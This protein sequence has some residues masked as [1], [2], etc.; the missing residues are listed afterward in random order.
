MPLDRDDLVLG[1]SEYV[2]G[3]YIRLRREASGHTLKQVA[4]KLDVSQP[5]L[6]KLERGEV[7]NP[8]SVVLAK[9]VRILR[10]DT[11][12]MEVRIDK[13]GQLESTLNKAHARAR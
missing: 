2:R 13:S 10:L 1:N 3:A 4:S 8:N 6:S 5:Y 7:K 9:L 12:C 11:F